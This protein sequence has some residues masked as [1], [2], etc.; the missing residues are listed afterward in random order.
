MKLVQ[1]HLEIMFK[2]P[3]F[4]TIA[5]QR[6]YFSIFVPIQHDLK[7]F[8]LFSFPTHLFCSFHNFSFTHFHDRKRRPRKGDLLRAHQTIIGMKRMNYS[9]FML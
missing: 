1:F 6:F 4:N 3:K 8:H 2:Q 9:D 7:I 5:I